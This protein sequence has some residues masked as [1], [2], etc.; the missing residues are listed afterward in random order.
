MVKSY[1]CHWLSSMGTITE[2]VRKRNWTKFVEIAQRFCFAANS[3]FGAII[4][5]T[6]HFANF[7]H[8]PI[9]DS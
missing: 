9:S 7:S 2:Y 4:N 5:W 1:A 8:L 6:A 3:Q